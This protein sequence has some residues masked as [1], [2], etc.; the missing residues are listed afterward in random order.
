[1]VGGDDRTTC[2]RPHLL[3]RLVVES[4]VIWI[5]GLRALPELAERV[6]P[7][8]LV[9]LVAP[10]DPV[11]TPRDVD[12]SRHLKIF[13]DDIIHDLAGAI[14]PRPRHVEALI[15]FAGDWDGARPMLIH[16]IAGISRSTAA[17]LIV[18]SA[19][20]EGREAEAALALR[21]AA[22]FARPNPR[23]ISL[24]DTLLGREGRLRGAVE[25]IGAA[26]LKALAYPVRFRLA[27][28]CS[29]TS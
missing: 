13:V 3:C 7:S 2:F 12:P 19:R 29:R 9:S 5:C 24:A 18:Q 6:R 8:R 21:R 4:D 10:G 17:A 1:M 15:D 25:A 14:A 20:C 16:C 27:D 28:A 22:P 11:D 26:D 23:L